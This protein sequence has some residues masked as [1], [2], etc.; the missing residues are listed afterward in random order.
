MF[1]VPNTYADGG[2]EIFTKQLTNFLQ[3][4]PNYTVTLVAHSMGTI[5]A[6]EI[7]RRHGRDLHIKAIVY[8]AAACG[9]EDFAKCVVPF[10]EADTNAVFYNLCLSPANERAEDHL[11]HWYNAPVEILAPHGSLL[12]W[13][14]DYYSTANTKF[15]WTM[16]KYEN[17]LPSMQA[18]MIRTNI[19]P[20]IM[21][22]RF[23]IGSLATCGP[24]KHGDF[25]QVRFWDTNFWQKEWT[26]N[27]LITGHPVLQTTGQ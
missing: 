19:Y 9:F 22:T 21:I 1:V 12:Q 6:N 18:S 17:V 16:G 20:R 7:I 13:I 2:A 24:Q 27:M 23:G 11:D 26:T 10:L 8:M 3:L 15:G 5:I 14:D 4:H 25:S